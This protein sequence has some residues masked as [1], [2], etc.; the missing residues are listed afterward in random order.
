MVIAVR[1]TDESEQALAVR[2]DGA[3]HLAVDRHHR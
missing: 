1:D 3:D 2:P